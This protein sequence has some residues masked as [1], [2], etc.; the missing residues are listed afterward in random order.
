VKTVLE[1]LTQ[2]H[3]LLLSVPRTNFRLRNDLYCVEWGVKLYS[4][5]HL[6]R[7]A[8]ALSAKAFQRYSA[9]SVWNSLSF[10]LSLG[11]AHSDEACSRPKCRTSHTVN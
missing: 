11:T 4:L 5:T 3:K 2:L 9:P 8:L 10:C 1:S 6:E 7:M